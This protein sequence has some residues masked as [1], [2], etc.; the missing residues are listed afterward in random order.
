MKGKKIVAI[1]LLTALALTGCG[2][3]TEEG[4]SI[5]KAESVSHG[6]LTTDSV[7]ISV[8]N[9]VVKY[10]EYQAYTYIL[11]EGYTKLLDEKIWNYAISPEHTIGKDAIEDTIRLIIQMKVMSKSAK[12]QGVELS[13]NEKEE[14]TF[15]AEQYV[16]GLSEEVRSKY[17]ISAQ[18]VNDMM[19]DNELARKLYD[20]VTG[21]VDTNVTTE[22]A[23]VVS[24]QVICF[25]T[26]G[27]D[28]N[29]TTHKADDQTKAALLE[30]AKQL[31]EKLDAGNFYSMAEA[32]TSLSD[33]KINYGHED[34]PKEVVNAVFAMQPGQISEVI[35]AT[36]GFYIV[37][38]LSINDEEAVKQHREELIAERQT[39]AF[40]TAYKKW[41][42]QYD[43]RVSESLLQ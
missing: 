39:T 33:V 38:C 8:G 37:N 5:E 21:K 10:N 41:S 9:T 34:S 28:K 20:V 18:L 6:K 43:V 15:K 30:Q 13:V 19:C 12:E 23:S 1:A 29:G 22:D 3:K 7:V 40:G 14:I 31:R 35:S 42:D 26:R 17:G 2:E 4:V 27:T 25:M 32:S 16:Q 36:D 11:Q 24:T